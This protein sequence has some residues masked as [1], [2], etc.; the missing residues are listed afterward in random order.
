MTDRSEFLDAYDR[1]RVVDQTEYYGR[2]AAEYEHTERLIGLINAALLFVAG[3]CGV[4]GVVFREESRWFGLTAAVLAAL[5]AASISWS[6]VIGFSANAE[7][8]R[9]AEASLERLRQTKPDETDTGAGDVEGYVGN[10]EDVLTGEVQTW[11]ERWA[12]E[13]E[14]V[15]GGADNDG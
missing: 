1:H 14:R 8:Y 10:V 2:T 7:L 12:R 15:E 9:A 6:D 11:G 4:L 5:A 3:I 13:I